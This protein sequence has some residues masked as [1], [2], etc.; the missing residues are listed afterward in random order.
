MVKV[1][2]SK[3]GNSAV[4][5]EVADGPIMSMPIKERLAELVS[6]HILEGRDITKGVATIGKSYRKTFYL[7]IMDV[8]NDVHSVEI[9][10]VTRKSAER[11]QTVCGQGQSPWLK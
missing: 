7:T 9:W 11:I 1:I 2:A 6:A 10:L 8:H 5:I 3:F 4:Q